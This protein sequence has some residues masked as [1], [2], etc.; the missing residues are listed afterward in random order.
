M[1]D[2]ESCGKVVVSKKEDDKF[3]ILKKRYDELVKQ[4]E[5][6]D[7]IYYEYTMY[8]QDLTT[9]IISEHKTVTNNTEI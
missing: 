3:L 2:I 6:V 1:E 8:L 5:I 9:K 4:M 7:S